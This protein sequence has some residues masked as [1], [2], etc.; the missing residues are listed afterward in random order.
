M[1]PGRTFQNLTATFHHPPQ[2]SY[3]VFNPGGTPES[4]REGFK[5][6]M[7]EVQFGYRDFEKSLLVIFLMN[8]LCWSSHEV[9]LFHPS[10]DGWSRCWG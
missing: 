10:P 5:T 4:S 9:E 6:F 7:A 1:Q 8:S 3:H 2:P